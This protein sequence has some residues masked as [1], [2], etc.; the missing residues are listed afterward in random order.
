M[1]ME[2]KLIVVFDKEAIGKRGVDVLFWRM[3]NRNLPAETILI[4]GDIIIRKSTV[5]PR[6]H[7]L[8]Q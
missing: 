6:I 2:K 8:H 5:T 7:D 3:A 1:S 4:R